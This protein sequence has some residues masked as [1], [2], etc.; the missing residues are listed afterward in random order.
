VKTEKNQGAKQ[1]FVDDGDPGQ[2]FG[3]DGVD[4]KGQRP[5]PGSVPTEAQAQG[6]A[7]LRELLSGAQE[8]A[9]GREVALQVDQVSGQPAQAVGPSAWVP[10]SEQICSVPLS[11]GRQ[12]LPASAP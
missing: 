3:E 2:G 9:L 7:Y 5:D 12:P 1:D 10:V 6:Q 8:Y 4:A 11:W